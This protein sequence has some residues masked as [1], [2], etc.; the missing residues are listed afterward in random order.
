MA[1]VRY[2]A[3]INGSVVEVT[4][5]GWR[6]LS[7]FKLF[8]KVKEMG[9]WYQIKEWL[10]AN[11]M[12]DAFVLAQVV[13]EDNQQFAAGVALFREKFGLTDDQVEEILSACVADEA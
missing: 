5:K 11:D 4:N 1:E 7:K 13:S 10:E 12:W 8:Q 2:A 6:K 9:Y 3:G